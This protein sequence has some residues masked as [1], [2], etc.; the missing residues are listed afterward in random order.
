MNA[1]I[2]VAMTI[3]VQYTYS[4]HLTLF[5][6]GINFYYKWVLV[7]SRTKKQ[8]G[9]KTGVGVG[10]IFLTFIF[11]VHCT[12][13]S[14]LSHWSKVVALLVVNGWQFCL[15]ISM[16][17]FPGSLC[18]DQCLCGPRCCFSCWMAWCLPVSMTKAA[19]HLTHRLISQLM[20]LF[21]SYHDTDQASCL[22]L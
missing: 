11:S 3:K 2:Y 19:A 5:G 1:T 12:E 16:A 9:D 10:G 4:D 21:L 13:I 7:C 18:A 14:F 6:T 20:S 8:V 17:W 22:F 15:C